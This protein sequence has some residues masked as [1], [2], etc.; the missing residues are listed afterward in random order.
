MMQEYQLGSDDPD[1][2]GDYDWVVHNYDAGDWSG[3]GTA[4]AYKDGQLFM[5][6]LGHC[7]CYGPTD[8]GPQVVDAASIDWSSLHSLAEL[9]NDVRVKVEELLSAKALQQSAKRKKAR[10]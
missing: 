7:S 8:D 2:S 5:W 4:A 3:S 9:D 6:N 10:E 1:I